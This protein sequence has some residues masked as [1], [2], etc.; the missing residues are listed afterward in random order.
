MGRGQGAELPVISRFDH[1]V[2]EQLERAGQRAP[3][4][5]QNTEHVAD[6]TGSGGRLGALAADIA[7]GGEPQAVTQT[8]YVVEVAAGA[9]W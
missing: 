3:I 1:E 6:L 4:T 5:D 9:G 2:V 7:D 8:E